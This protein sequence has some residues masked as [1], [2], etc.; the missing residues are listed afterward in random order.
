VEQALLSQRGI[1]FMELHG[2]VGF[3]G[4]ELGRAALKQRLDYRVA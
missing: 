3:Q 1:N 4:L 2:P